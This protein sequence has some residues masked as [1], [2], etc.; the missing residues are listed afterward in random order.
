MSK[1]DRGIKELEKLLAKDGFN[2]EESNEDGTGISSRG[3][4]TL[5]FN[6]RKYSLD[7]ERKESIPNASLEKDREDND[8]LVFR[9]NRKK[10][11]VYMDLST[12]ILMLLNNRS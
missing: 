10:W 11:K 5:T 12:L 3:D 4:L 6:G 8:M 7:I 9:K 2:I 1:K